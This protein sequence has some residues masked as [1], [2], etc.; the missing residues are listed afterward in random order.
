MLNGRVDTVER[1]IHAYM[2]N[3]RVKE[4]RPL[5]ARA[6][7]Y[8]RCYREGMNG[9][10]T[11]ARVKADRALARKEKG[12]RATAA[13]GST[14]PTQTGS[15]FATPGRR[16]AA[17]KQQRYWTTCHH[18]GTTVDRAKAAAFRKS[19]SA[20]V[21]EER[22]PCMRKDPGEYQSHRRSPTDNLPAQQ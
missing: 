18:C 7:A 3:V 15:C 4:M 13:A 16:P 20:N 19:R 12:K 6:E 5:R 22:L 11:F 1:F 10:E 8:M 14:S 9:A 21:Q 17:R 2:S